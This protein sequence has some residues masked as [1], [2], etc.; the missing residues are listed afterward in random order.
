MFKFLNGFIQEI[1]LNLYKFEIF[2]DYLK[3]PEEIKKLAKQLLSKQQDKFSLLKSRQKFLTYI[4]S[5]FVSYVIINKGYNEF[6]EIINNVIQQFN[7]NRKFITR[8][9]DLNK[10]LLVIRD[11]GYHQYLITKSLTA[12]QKEIYITN[13]YKNELKNFLNKLDEQ[14]NLSW[15]FKELEELIEPTV[16]LVRE[17]FEPFENFRSSRYSSACYYLLSKIKKLQRI[18]I[19]LDPFFRIISK[20]K[21]NIID[22]T[23]RIEDNLDYQAFIK[24]FPNFEFIEMDSVNY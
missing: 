18:K 17:C 22:H 7:N 3:V 13:M 20:S 16:Y 24:K 11:K 23:K 4:A 5:F 14:N 2:C 1:N 12:E 19:P 9:V 6:K 8:Y 15:Y 21:F 10:M